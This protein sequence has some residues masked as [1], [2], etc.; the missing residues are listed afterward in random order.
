MR[1]PDR[2]IRPAVSLFALVSLSLAPAGA[3]ADEAE[4][5][6]APALAT[7][8]GDAPYQFGPSVVT[9]RDP[10]THA[11]NFYLGVGMGMTGGMKVPIPIGLDYELMKPGLLYV[12]AH[13]HFESGSLLND[14]IDLLVGPHAT[15][16]GE[17]LGGYP[18]LSWP[19]TTSGKWALDSENFT[20]WTGSE[21]KSGQTITFI[22]PTLP[23]RSFLIGE[24]GVR[25]NTLGMA[26]KFPEDGS[27]T[28]VAGARYRW[29]HSARLVTTV[30]Q[31]KFDTTGEGYTAIWAHM[32]AGTPGS[33]AFFD[34]ARI[35]KDTGTPPATYSPV[36]FEAGVS[37]AFWLTSP[38][39]LEGVVGYSPAGG[40]FLLCGM[41]Y[42]LWTK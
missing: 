31:G 36:G 10:V 3:R 20:R 25:R 14:L 5:A 42:R 35:A 40:L 11:V 23:A 19:G 34:A 21:L 33:G 13:L 41:S 26:G 6:P 4:P 8:I 18:I 22:R 9:P 7:E 30:A 32:L 27:F 39:N 17:I 2:S 24:A 15:Y 38:I 12:R 29:A 1:P 28:F 16:G 37:S